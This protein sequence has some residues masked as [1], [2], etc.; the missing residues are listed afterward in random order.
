MPVITLCRKAASRSQ[1][2]CSEAGA[3]CPLGQCVTEW[4]S[5][6]AAILISGGA[7]LKGPIGHDSG[8]IFLGP[9]ADKDVRGNGPQ[10]VC[11]KGR[12]LIHLQSQGTH[13]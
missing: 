3:V 9:G 2:A 5:H 11:S 8:F 10:S 7:P 1:I 13:W 12:H 4:P 6:L